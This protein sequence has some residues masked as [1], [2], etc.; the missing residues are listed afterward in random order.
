MNRPYPHRRAQ[1]RVKEIEAYQCLICGRVREN[2][3]GHH[4]IYYS[5]NGPPDV[6]NMVT[7]CPSCHTDWHNGDLDV[8]IHRF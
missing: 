6:Q 8:D 3:A 1:K 5:E 2:A 4:L 7:L